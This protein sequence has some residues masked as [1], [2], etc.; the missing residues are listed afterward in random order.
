MLADPGHANP[1]AE[2][3]RMTG[4]IAIDAMTRHCAV[5]ALS[6]IFSVTNRALLHFLCHILKAL[7]SKYVKKAFE[8]NAQVC[9]IGGTRQMLL[10]VATKSE[11][12]D[13]LV[14]K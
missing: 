4:S 3:R 6:F 2:K 11:K 14:R 12:C 13:K 1:A 10:S 8:I 7:V 9:R 5:F